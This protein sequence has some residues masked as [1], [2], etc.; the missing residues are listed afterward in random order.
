VNVTDT[1]EGFQMGI[2]NS[3]QRLSGLQMAV[4][5]FAEDLYGLQIGLIN[6]IRSKDKYPVLPLVNWK[7]EE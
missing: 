4:V 6:I 1:G 2:F 7:Y 5:N 3:T